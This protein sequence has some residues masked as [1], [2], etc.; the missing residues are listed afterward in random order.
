MHRQHV[1]DV[2]CSGVIATTN[3]LASFRISPTPM[4]GGLPLLHAAPVRPA[5]VP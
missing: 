5:I 4:H 2:Y 3:R 1:F